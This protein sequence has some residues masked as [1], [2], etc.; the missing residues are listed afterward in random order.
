MRNLYA[1][2]YQQEGLDS[3]WV[4]LFKQ[5]VLVLPLQRAHAQNV[6]CKF[7]IHEGFYP[8][9]MRTRTGAEEQTREILDVAVQLQHALNKL[10]NKNLV[11]LLQA[12][13]DIE[14]QIFCRVM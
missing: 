1:L 4:T 3:F 6:A 14:P 2:Q 13:C 5:V 7:C 8:L 10:T 9:R 11:G 12:V